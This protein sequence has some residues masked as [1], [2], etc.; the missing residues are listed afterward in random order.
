[1]VQASKFRRIVKG[2]GNY[3]KSDPQAAAV[4]SERAKVC[5]D[6]P[7]AVHGTYER[8]MPD[9]SLMLV[10]GMKC[11]EC[12]CPLSTKLRVLEEECPLKKWQSCTN[13]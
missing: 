12:G 2:W 7:S 4:A 11:D 3:L 10:Q 9:W 1:M 5:A 8:V 13:C 6:C